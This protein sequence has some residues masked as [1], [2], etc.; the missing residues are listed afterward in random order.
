[1]YL[2]KKIV[3][4][5]FLDSSKNWVTAN[6]LANH[7]HVS[8]RTIRK[9]VTE[10][11]HGFN[12]ED[13]F[14]LSSKKG[15]KINPNRPYEN[16][17][18]MDE[19][20]FGPSERITFILQKIIAHN[21]GINI[22]DVS[23]YLYLSLPTIEKD[24]QTA[25]RKLLKF[26]LKIMRRDDV[27]FLHGLEKNKR[28]L[29]S[30][31]I[32]TN[33]SS[34]FLNIKDI[35][36]AYFDYDIVRLKQCMNDILNRNGLYINAYS[37]NS[38]LL[39]M[40]I[41]MDR[42]KNHCPI[43]PIVNYKDLP[44]TKERNAAI[45]FAKEIKQYFSITFDDAEIYYIALLLKSKTSLLNYQSVTA[46]NLSQYI[47]NDYIQLVIKLLKKLNENYFIEIKD[48]DFFI[49]FTI[50]VRNLIFRAR[51]SQT[52]K[53]PLAHKIKYS[54]PLIYEL[55]IFIAN[56]LQKLEAI[57]IHEDEIA[58]IAFHIGSYFQRCR[59]LENKVL[60]MVICPNYYD[61]H[62]NVVEMLDQKFQDIL[63]IIAVITDEN[64]IIPD[65]IDLVISTVELCKI[66]DVT[67]I[68]ISPFMTTNDVNM[69]Q[70]EI[71]IQNRRKIA[72]KL[73]D[74]LTTFFSADLFFK[75]IYLADS[76]A[77]IR[78]LSGQLYDKGYVNE[79]FERSV[80][81]REALSSTAFSNNV[82]VP[83]A[84]KMC[85]NRTFI[86]II[87][88]DKP[89]KWDKEY[90]QIIVM[91]GIKESERKIFRTVFESIISILSDLD[92]VKDLVK[93]KNYNYFLDKITCLMEN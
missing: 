47:E 34:Q 26:D 11:N 15:Y 84:M 9:Y 5:K 42:T 23:E 75:N 83:H 35:Q 73:R 65:N 50:H 8:T 93:S 87:L 27:L 89:V 66:T 81:E 7:F 41:T 1:M 4:L 60:C 39:H 25:N 31:M 24:I 74:Y 63:E 3:F 33:S 90:I 48:N 36:K 70:H 72:K 76:T 30:Q 67:V 51:H 55:A 68:T 52:L 18:P 85:S 19:K 79:D 59:E 56:E 53:N 46:K 37:M 88:N 44:I 21:Q 38:I 71:R 77:Y 61:M 28:K 14:I 49:K 58:Y 17:Q 6:T 13:G 92:N 16:G 45:E 62:L 78:Y 29:M 54:Y 12:E 80:L 69:L 91:I 57:T 2:N 32:Y 20:D 82:A 22:F 10:I 40:V 64:F 86:S 43:D